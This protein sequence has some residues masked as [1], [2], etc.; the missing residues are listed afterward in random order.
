MEEVG[1]YDE[2]QKKELKKMKSNI[3]ILREVNKLKEDEILNMN[4]SQLLEKLRYNF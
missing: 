1:I 3:E 2:E 4:D